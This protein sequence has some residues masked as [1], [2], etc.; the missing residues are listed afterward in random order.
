MFVNKDTIIS[1]VTRVEVYEAI[2]FC[3]ARDRLS[4]RYNGPTD[5]RY[6]NK[7]AFSL[8]PP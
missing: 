8:F 5:F 6:H 1:F 4:V 3:Q 7:P 2:K